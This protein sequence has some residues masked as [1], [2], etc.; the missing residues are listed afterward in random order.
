MMQGQLTIVR[1]AFFTATGGGVGV[2]P[3]FD[4]PDYNLVIP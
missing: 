2:D 4:D 3:S 1:G